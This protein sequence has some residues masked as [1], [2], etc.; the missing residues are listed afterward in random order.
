MEKLE[1][2]VSLESQV[3][4]LSLQ[5]KLGK[6]N[7]H[8]DK[9]KVFE[10]ITNTIKDTSR[11]ITN[12]MTETSINNNKALENL[13]DKLLEIM[14]D[15]GIKA[16]YLLSPLSK[17][18]NHE[19]TSQFELVKDSDSKRVY[20]L[21]INKTIS[22]TLYNNLLRFRD[23]DKEIELQGDILKMMTNKNYNVDLVK[24][25][26]NKLLYEIAKEMYYDE[27]ALGSKSTR[28]K[29]LVIT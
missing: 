12:T 14:N 28:D 24:L 29:S 11:D 15:R 17:N 21:L 9:K 26:D 10:P 6:Q 18:T 20:D 4:A 8:E 19:N 13:N 16:S 5:D 25:S 27:K 3:K 22:V 7:I 2:L 1:E 23:T